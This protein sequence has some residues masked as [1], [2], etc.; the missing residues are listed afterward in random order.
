MT[1][2]LEEHRWSR[3][4]YPLQRPSKAAQFGPVTLPSAHAK[5]LSLEEGAPLNRADGSVPWYQAV[6]NDHADGRLITSHPDNKSNISPDRYVADVEHDNDALTAAFVSQHLI[7]QPNGEDDRQPWLGMTRSI[8]STTQFTSFGQNAASCAPTPRTGDTDQPHAEYE[9]S[10]EESPSSPE[11]EDDSSRQLSTEALNRHGPTKRTLRRTPRSRRIDQLPSEALPSRESPILPAKQEKNASSIEFME[12]SQST[13]MLEANSWKRQWYPLQALLDDN[14]VTQHRSTSQ[15]GTQPGLVFES[16]N[17]EAADGEGSSTENISRVPR[18]CPWQPPE[19]TLG[20]LP[21]SPP[22]SDVE[23]ED[24]PE[25]PAP[26]TI[27]KNQTFKMKKSWHRQ[28]Y[29][30]Q[31]PASKRDEVGR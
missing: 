26:S 4:R 15:P 10:T 24:A 23:T 12:S 25:P 19:S 21:A 16:P 27:E 14:M 29:P 5:T 7:S 6:T 11:P 30:L 9:T 22:L 18:A 17:E 13:Q 8:Q 28:T 3:S 20:N 31:A 1:T 2:M